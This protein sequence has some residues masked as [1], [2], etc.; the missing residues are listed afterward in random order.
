VLL[1]GRR[2]IIQLS[3]NVLF[4]VTEILATALVAVSRITAVTTLVPP[5]RLALRIGF[6]TGGVVRTLLGL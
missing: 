4:P 2:G 5:V 1:P 3:P 6:L